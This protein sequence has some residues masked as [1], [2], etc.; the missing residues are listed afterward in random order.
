MPVVHSADVWRRTGRY[1]EVDETMVRF[2]DRR[3]RDMVLGMTHEEIVAELASRDIKSYRDAGIVVYQIQTKF[4][5]ERR[6]RGGL[7]RAREFIM[8]DAY[9]LHLDETGMAEAYEVQSQAYE[10]IFARLGLRDVHRIRSA[11]GVMGGNVSH[12]FMCMLDAGEDT[13]VFCADCGDA[14]NKEV[15]GVLTC[16][17]CGREGEPRRGVEV[18]NIFQLGVRYTELLDAR[19]TG[20]DGV[21]RPIVMGSYGIGISRLLATLVEQGHDDKG[22]ALTAATAPFDAHIVALGGMSRLEDVAADI[23]SRC[24]EAGVDVIWDDRRESAGQ[25][26]ADADLIGATVRVTVGRSTLD[27]GQ[28]ELR[29]RRNGRIHLVAPADVT[30]ALRSLIDDIRT[31]EQVAAF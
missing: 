4:R 14:W 9:S 5:D 8:K 19:A 3:G 20:Q 15:S 12:E 21:T 28:V 27:A 18:G 7:L 13:V 2:K 30:Q 29:E 17:S 23:Y 16:A 10:R 6:P 25:Q 26:L 24:V 1:D 22:I 31:D 11:S